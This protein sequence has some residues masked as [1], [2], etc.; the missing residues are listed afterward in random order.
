[1]TLTATTILS[2]PF[3]TRILRPVAQRRTQRPLLY[4]SQRQFSSLA[5]DD[6]SS[7]E[8]EVD[9]VWSKMDAKSRRLAKLLLDSDDP[10]DMASEDAPDEATRRLRENHIFNRRRGLSQAITLIESSHADH[11]KQSNLLLT[12]LLGHENNHNRKDRS[13]RLGIAGSPGAGKSTFVEA[14]GK[15]LLNLPKDDNPDADSHEQCNKVAVVCVDP[16]SAVTGGSILGDK[17]RMMELSRHERA[18]VRPSPT[19]NVLGGLSAYTE[20]VVSLC[21]VAGYDFVMLETVGLGQSEIEVKESVDM[22]I[23]MVP[24]GGGDDLQGI[25][26]GIVE[27]CD[28]IVVTKADGNFLVAAKHTAADYRGALRMMGPRRAGLGSTLEGWETPPVLL[29][30]SYDNTGMDD[31]WGEICRFRNLMMESGKLQEKRQKQTKYWMWK[32]LQNLILEQTRTDHV[33]RQKAE[34]LE[35]DLREGKTTPRV[36]ATELLDSLVRT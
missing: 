10:H 17:T 36:A 14:F 9:A 30:S 25:K 1:M 34:T 24:P 20:D 3:L 35:R 22:L 7:A 6:S 31:V 5:S 29:A 16:S 33:L 27:V 11:Q 12:Y 15:H 32:N 23:L 28:M 26:K 4:A 8:E 13:F 18:Y 2:R 19:R 21:Q